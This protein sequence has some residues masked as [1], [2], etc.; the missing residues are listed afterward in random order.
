MVNGI[1]N[2]CDSGSKRDVA[3]S[4]ATAFKGINEAIILFEQSA[5]SNKGK[6]H[7][8]QTLS[9]VISNCTM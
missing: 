5:F 7:N 4:S 9:V 8:L 6:C 1:T 2:V 3:L